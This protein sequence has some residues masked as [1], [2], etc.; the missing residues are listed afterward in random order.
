[1]FASYYDQSAEEA[2]YVDFAHGLGYAPFFLA[3]FS[4]NNPPAQADN[5]LIEVPWSVQL[6]DISGYLYSVTGWADATRVRLSFWRGSFYDT[7]HSSIN[8]NW[9]NE[10]ITLKL[11]VF[12]ENLAGS[13]NL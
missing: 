10:T 13:E 3:Y 2:T 4:S 12:T 7:I 9:T 11:I 1:M 8:G 5:R 6:S